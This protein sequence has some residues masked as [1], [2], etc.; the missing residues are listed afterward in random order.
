MLAIAWEYLTG[1]SVATD[2]TD[3]LSA[4]WPPHPDRVCQ[5]LVAA[6]GNADADDTGKAALDWLMA[7]PPPQLAVPKDA[8][9][10][11]VVKT[12]V[13]VNDTEGPSR[14]AYNEKQL[15]LLPQQRMRKERYFPATN[16]GA[17]TCALIWPDAD[18]GDFR[19]TL[20]DICAQVTNIGHSSSLVR[21]WI[22]DDPPAA[23]LMPSDRHGDVRLRVSGP[24]RLDRLCTAFAQDQRPPMS[25][26]QSYEQQD[27]EKDKVL[28][29]AFDKRL[30]VLRQVGG[31]RF[32]LVQAPALI[33][34][35]RGTLIKAADK[36]PL[37]KSLFSGH[38]PGTTTPMQRSHVA[39]LPLPAVG[40]SE[41]GIGDRFSDGHLLGLALALP[42]DVD[43][44]EEQAIF[45]CLAQAF[46]FGEGKQ[47]L[48]LG[49]AGTMEIRLDEQE[50]VKRALRPYTWTQA[51]AT[52]ATVCPIAL[53]R[54]PPRRHA[55]H[56]AWAA[57]QIAIA[58]ERQGLP[59]PIAIRL[60]GT[61]P[62]M[63]VPHPRH[64]PPLIRGSGQRSWHCNALIQFP[65]RVSGPLLLGAGRYKGYG[66]CR[67]LPYRSLTGE[68]IVEDTP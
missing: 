36:I 50:V 2:P 49:K 37:A 40:D 31:E 46:N 5:A 3:R 19:Q 38:E 54:M 22:C 6:W 27:E 63:G 66:L 44:S 23:T 53:D 24:G 14:S 17:E 1:R 48:T 16:V 35:L 18:A 33:Q 13:P 10:A 34:A 62:L 15:K 45:T 43:P 30:I 56:D 8:L 41:G 7:Q 20:A 59:A 9:E 4:E 28:F 11:A 47:V 21:M 61:G 65:Q 32:N 29:G 64:I 57:E 67:P 39:L 42:R 68:Q 52:W 58:C 26:W 55:D 12:Y 25:A 51:S 60:T